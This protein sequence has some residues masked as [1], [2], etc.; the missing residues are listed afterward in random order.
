MTSDLDLF[1]KIDGIEGESQDSKHPRE[2]K[3]LSFSKG[4]NHSIADAQG[5][6]AGRSKWDDAQFTMRVDRGYPKLFDSCISG[7]NLP[8]AILTFR[9]AGKAQQEF[10][11]IT[12]SDVMVSRCEMNGSHDADPT[13]FVT[14]SFNFSRIEEE[15]RMQNADGTLSGPITYMYSIRKGQ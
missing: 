5:A 9:K 8:K 10:L 4:V 3:I 6:D 15:Y 2:L 12:F 14:F 11:K 13:P 7:A 1:L